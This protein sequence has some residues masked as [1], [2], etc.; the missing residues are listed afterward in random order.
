MDIKTANQISIKTYL[1]D[2]GIYPVK[3][4]GHYGMYRSP[5]REDNTASMK[6][7]Y[8]KNLWMDYGTGEGGALIDLVM[9]IEN[10]SLPDSLRKLEQNRTEP[11]SFSFHGNNSVPADRKPGIKIEEI[12]S[13]THP[14]LLNYLRE[15]KLNPEIAKLYCNEVHY[16]INGKIYFAIGFRNDSGGYELRNRTFK[17]CTSKDM[18]TLQTDHTDCLLFEGFIDYL[19]LLTLKK[20][21]RVSQNAVILNSVYNLHKVENQLS[22]Y[23]KIYSFLDNDEAGRSA[24]IKVKSV[25]KNVVDLSGVYTGYKDLNDYLQ[26]KSPVH[27]LRL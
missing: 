21:N 20:Q 24:V 23:D 12:V 17:G 4:Y 25:C 22:G 1:A 7:D 6:V 10:C 14:A 5:F 19:S 13:I 18:T 26:G 11:A 3:D 15:R 2:H 27:K 9:K 8:N 16:S